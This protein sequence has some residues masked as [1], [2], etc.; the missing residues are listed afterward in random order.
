MMSYHCSTCGE[1]HDDLPDIGVDRPETKI[2]HR[3]KQGRIFGE[4]VYA[5]ILS[6]NQQIIH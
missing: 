1:I 5:L 6:L 4:M 2:Q 3:L